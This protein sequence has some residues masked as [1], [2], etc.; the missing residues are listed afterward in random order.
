[1]LTKLYHQSRGAAETVGQKPDSVRTI[2]TEVCALGAV[3]VSVLGCVCACSAKVQQRPP[4]LGDCYP[5]A[6]AGCSPTLSSGGSPAAPPQDAAR[7]DASAPPKDATSGDGSG[8]SQDAVTGTS[9]DAAVGDAVDESG[10]DGGPCGTAH[11][12][13]RTQ[14][15][16]CSPCIVQQC[17]QADDFCSRDPVCRSLVSSAFP[18][19]GM[20]MCQSETPP[21]SCTNFLDFATCIAGCPSC[22]TLTLRDF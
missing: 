19:P 7:G 1:M 20:P 15:P 17:C 16:M 11:T 2:A 22:P 18:G 9:Q 10:D 5:E 21:A 13:V 6:G 4:E 3:L 14:N 8:A 12:G